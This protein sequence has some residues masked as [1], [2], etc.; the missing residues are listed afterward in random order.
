MQTVPPADQIGKVYYATHTFR[1]YGQ[2]VT[3]H[4]IVTVEPRGYWMQE[5]AIYREGGRHGGW[6][7]VTGTTLHGYI[8]QVCGCTAQTTCE[9]CYDMGRTGHYQEVA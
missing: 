8:G 2:I 9:R 5:E 1:V 3:A 6:V 4:G 7:P